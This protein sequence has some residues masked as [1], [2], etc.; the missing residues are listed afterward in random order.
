MP[1]TVTVRAGP[2]VSRE[3]HATLPAALDALQEHLDALSRTARRGPTRAFAREYEPV[4]QVAARGEVAGPTRLLPRIR[5]GVDVRGDGSAEAYRG[6]VRRE[7]VAQR[8][9][10]TAYDAL[11]RVLGG[12]G[13]QA[14]ERDLSDA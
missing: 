7:L 2:K 13:A 3:R 12:E 10:E 4:A 1:Y 9:G 8:P 11:R 14:V 5:A 6:R